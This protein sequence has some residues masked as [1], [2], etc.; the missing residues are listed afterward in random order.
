MKEQSSNIFYRPEWTC[1][2]LSK[3][4][5]AAIY[6]NLIDGMAYF[7]EDYSAQVIGVILSLPRNGSIELQRWSDLTG[8]AENSLMSFADSLMEMGLLV[9]ERP[10]KELVRRY[11]ATI[12]KDLATE[13]VPV[14][15]MAKDDYPLEMNDAELAYKEKVGG[16]ISVMFELTYNCSEKCIHCYNIGATRNDE[17]QSFRNIQKRLS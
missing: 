2:R 14:S 4:A 8:I 13:G 5:D 11:R 12:H 1:G 6:Y 10:T 16:V 9:S 3:E 15:D 17:E 7:F